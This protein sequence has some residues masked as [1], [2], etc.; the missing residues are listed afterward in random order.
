VRR[1]KA[2]ARAETEAGH[3][4][5]MDTRPDD[6]E[7]RPAAATELELLRELERAAGEQFRG[8]GM[9]EI[10]DDEPL[11]PEVLEEYRRAGRAW[12][13]AGRNGRP[14]A[15]LLHDEVDGAAHVEQVSVHPDA[16][17]R[18]LGRALIDQLGERARASGLRALT[19]TTFAEV[20][21]NAPYYA[22]LGFRPL[23]DAQLGEGLRE[24]RR[25]EKEHGL[26]RRP[27][28]CMR[29]ELPSAPDSS[30]SARAGSGGS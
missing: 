5:P 17:G 14:L 30:P 29:R 21:W 22:R 27:R 10:A 13:A 25:R 19:L 9:S 4:D 1:N 6:I 16:A 18:G 7:I 15:Y 8:I 2:R 12:V 20:P 3:T 23:P 11:P 28:I 24:I 26:D